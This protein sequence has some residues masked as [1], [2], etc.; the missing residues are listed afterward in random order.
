[1]SVRF[2]S[3]GFV[4]T[5]VVLCAVASHV[6]IAADEVRQYRAGELTVGE[7][8]QADPGASNRW[9]TCTVTGVQERRN[10]AGVADF[11]TLYC[12]DG[13]TY[14]PN[15]DTRHVRKIADARADNPAANAAAVAAVPHQLRRGDVKVGNQ[16]VADPGASN[17]WQNCTVR[18]L[19]MRRDDPVLI[20]LATMECGG[21]TY[22]V[23]ADTRHIPPSGA[24]PAPNVSAPSPAQRPNLSRSAPTKVAQR[25]AAPVNAGGAGG[26]LADGKYSCARQR[27]SPKGDMVI[28]GNTWTFYPNPAGSPAR[29]TYALNGTALTWTGPLGPAMGYVRLT[30]SALDGVVKNSFWF[31]ANTGDTLDATFS[32]RMYRAGWADAATIARISGMIIGMDISES[33]SSGGPPTLAH[34][35]AVLREQATPLRRRGILHAGVFGS[36]AP[37]EATAASDVDICRDRLRDRVQHD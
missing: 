36:I 15:A 24:A 5:L 21:I 26:K 14:T 7:R 35:L 4:A 10:E 13:S 37:G 30:R 2:F 31:T 11:V 19:T 3:I 16:V 27:F 23:V 22:D 1:M 12:S 25:I 28:R 29:G 32:C 8:V 34:V 17:R 9:Q 18:A 33:T 6:A 20:E